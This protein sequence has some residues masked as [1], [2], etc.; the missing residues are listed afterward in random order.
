MVLVIEVL[1]ALPCEGFFSCCL[2]HIYAHHS[3]PTVDGFFREKL[4]ERVVVVIASLTLLK[5]VLFLE[6]LWE[7]FPFDFEK[8]RVF[9]VEHSELNGT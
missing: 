6:R 3:L 4:L 9:S 7:L 2:F 5:R 1:K 8:V